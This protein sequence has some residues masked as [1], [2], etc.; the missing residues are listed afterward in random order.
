[1]ATVFTSDATSKQGFGFG[2][3]VEQV[4][5]GLSQDRRQ[6]GPPTGDGLQVG[7]DLSQ[8]RRQTDPPTGDGLR[9][10]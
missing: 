9:R 10:T 4:G 7:G 5:G 8:N 2:H 6:T 3:K 1:M